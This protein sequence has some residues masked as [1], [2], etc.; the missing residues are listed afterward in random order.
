MKNRKCLKLLNATSVSN[1][2]ERLGCNKQMSSGL[3]PFHVSRLNEDGTKLV[4][5]GILNRAFAAD[6]MESQNGGKFKAISGSEQSL[7]DG[8]KDTKALVGEFGTGEKWRILRNIFIVSISYMLIFTGMAGTEGLQSSM[9]A[10]RGLGT[11][12]MAGV[13]FGVVTANIFFSTLVIRWLGCKWTMV[14]AMAGMMPFV[15]AQY[16]ASFYSLVPLGILNGLATGVNWVAASTYITVASEAYANITKTAKEIVLTRFFA[17]FFMFYQS[18]QIF[19]SLISSMVFSHQQTDAGRRDPSLCGLHFCPAPSNHSVH[20]GASDGTVIIIAGSYLCVMYGEG[21]RQSS[22]SKSSGL[23]L[24]Y[25]TFKVFIEERSV[26]LVVPITFFLGLEK[27]FIMSSFTHAFITC[28]VGIT[29]VGFVL[30][31]FGLTNAFTTPITTWIAKHT[32]RVPVV[33]AASIIHIGIIITLIAWNPHPTQHYVLYT[34]AALWGIAEGIWMV[35]INALYGLVFRGKEEAAFSNYRVF[36]AAGYTIGYLTSSFVCTDIQLYALLAVLC[37]GSACYTIVEI[38]ERHNRVAFMFSFMTKYGTGN[39]QS[40][41]NAA[42]GLGTAS[43]AAIYSGLV[44][45]NATLPTLILRWFGCKW[46]M[47][48]CFLLSAPYIGFQYRPTFYSLVPV[49]LLAGVVAAPMSV[50]ANKYLAVTA[51]AYTD[52]TGT[53]MDAV[54][55]KFFGGFLLFCQMAQVWGNLITSL[56]REQMNCGLSYCPSKAVTNPNFRHPEDQTVLILIYI[57]VGA[58]IVAAILVSGIDSLRRYSDG[59]HEGNGVTATGF[60]LLGATFKELAHEKSLQLL[61]P[62]TFWLGLEQAFMSADYTA[63]YVSCSWGLGDVGYVMTTYGLSNAL[64]SLI[65]GWIVK[66]TGRV[67]AIMVAFFSHLT[68]IVTMVFWHPSPSE[69]SVFFAITLLWGV[70]DAIWV[71]QIICNRPIET[72]I[73]LTV[74]NEVTALRRTSDSRRSRS[75]IYKNVMVIGVVWTLINT[76]KDGVTNIQSSVN[77]DYG[78]GTAALIALYGGV[79]ISNTFLATAVVRW[80]GTKWT[81]VWMMVIA[82][83]SIA[84][85]TCSWGVDHIGYVLIPYGFTNALSSFATGWL[86]RVT[87]R[88]ILMATSFFLHFVITVYLLTW[89]PDPDHHFMTFYCVTALWGIANGIHCMDSW[90]MEKR[91]H[92]SV[93]MNFGSLWVS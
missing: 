28:S 63:A 62:L 20:Q 76:I 54:I 72:H 48:L 92:L 29:N 88:W 41:L 46:T 36:R 80:L 35:Q 49:S 57:F 73:E 85:V 18:A 79:V 32:G 78:L 56:V 39:L 3:E 1:E 27:C 24:L 65:I 23:K 25:V 31:A 21:V 67:P 89:S 55:P 16:R 12:S 53:P 68:I 19:G 75:R 33:I 83:P 50:A 2:K 58:L 69:K 40:S 77:S 61:L 26:K 5:I 70:A 4:P 71:V 30:I 45:S 14:L 37:L 86:V 38:R 51:Q 9:N 44:V 90:Q 15:A 7:K 47:V 42:H 84:Y 64:F 43:L 52:I 13:Y 81:L 34:I 11:I 93:T 59:D 10:A 60:R 6:I 66:M 82:L 22:S 74:T 17:I 91:M 8:G 87:G